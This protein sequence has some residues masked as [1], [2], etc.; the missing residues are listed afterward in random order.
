VLISDI[1]MPEM[2]GY[3]FIRSVR[4][5]PEGS[6]GKTPAIALTAFARSNDRS[7]AMDVRVALRN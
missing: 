1:G 5:L 7:R 6:G 2:D 4:R 3:E